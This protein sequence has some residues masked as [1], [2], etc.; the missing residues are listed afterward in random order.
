VA[1]KKRAGQL[2][3]AAPPTAGSL[4]VIDDPAVIVIG[5]VGEVVIALVKAF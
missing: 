4:V 5:F 3:F 1:V 2:R